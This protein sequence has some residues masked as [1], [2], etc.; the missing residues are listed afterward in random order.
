MLAKQREDDDTA[1][2]P[3]ERLK[4]VG[5]RLLEPAKQ[6]RER[7]RRLAFFG[8]ALDRMREQRRQQPERYARLA[9]RLILLG[10]AI[11]L[12]VSAYILIADPS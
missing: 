12:A 5:E 6:A 3:T 4:L 2:V 8:N 11:V 9:D 7:G 1:E 10:I